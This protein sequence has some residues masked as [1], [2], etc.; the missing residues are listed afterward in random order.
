MLESNYS[1]NEYSKKYEAGVPVVVGTNKALK[2]SETKG[3]TTEQ[4]KTRKRPRNEENPFTQSAEESNPDP[5]A[6]LSREKEPKTVK[7][8]PDNKNTRRLGPGSRNKRLPRGNRLKTSPK[9]RQKQG[10][11]TNQ[12]PNKWLARLHATKDTTINPTN[13]VAIRVGN[14][15][16][17]E[18]PFQATKLLNLKNLGNVAEKTEPPSQ[19]PYE[20]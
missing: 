18:G 2:G 15:A 16:V 3:K 19:L 5:T 9:G 7:R 6:G 20:G 10:T 12:K 8:G 13:E 1:N 11:I 17:S 14:R 4:S